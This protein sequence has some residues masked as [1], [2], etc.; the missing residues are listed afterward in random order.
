MLAGYAQAAAD[1]KTVRDW[2]LEIEEFHAEYCCLSH[3]R[4]RERR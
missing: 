1:P 4:A 3:H 2:R